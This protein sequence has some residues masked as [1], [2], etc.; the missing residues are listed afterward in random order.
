MI[1]E[2]LGGFP[3]GHAQNSLVLWIIIAS[4]VTKKWP[5]I[6]AAFVCLL[7]GFSRI[8]L[9]V[10]FPTDI[11]GGWI[12]AALILCIYFFARERIET[13]LS[14]HYPRAGLY[15]CAALAFG[16]ILYRPSIELI[17]PA[18]LLL[19]MGIGYFLC[20]RYVGF[21]AS[22]T[23]KTGTAKYRTLILRFVLGIMVMA[24]LSTAVEK[25]AV[26]LD[27]TGN[28]PLYVFLLMTL[29]AL[30]VSAGAPWLFC[31]LRLADALPL[32]ESA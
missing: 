30:W 10:H 20:R 6:V 25:F 1:A 28:Y 21:T 23:G 15:S 27:Q 14:A 22:T 19:G 18:G 16:M 13:L 32:A 7:I 3:S 8:Y 11:L 2:K 24:V 26:G 5:Y 12:I 9:G 29:V 31:K 17:M 4:W